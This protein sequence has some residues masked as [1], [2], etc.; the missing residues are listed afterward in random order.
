MVASY[1]RNYS[2]FKH[3]GLFPTTHVVKHS[4]EHLIFSS[5]FEFG[6]ITNN[7]YQLYRRIYFYLEWHSPNISPPI[8][9]DEL[10]A[11]IFPRPIIVLYGTSQFAKFASFSTY[12]ITREY[13]FTVHWPGVLYS[14]TDFHK[15]LSW[16]FWRNCETLAQQ[17][18]S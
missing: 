6:R 11:N 5:A 8:L 1:H 13:F 4:R 18:F 17:N 9:W 15:K 7:N 16:F 2:D 10:F 12:G 14:H 3:T